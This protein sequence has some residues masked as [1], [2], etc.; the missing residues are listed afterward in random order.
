MRQIAPGTYV[1]CDANTC[2]VL[3]ARGFPTYQE[4][5]LGPSSQSLSNASMVVVTPELRTYFTVVNTSLC[6]DITPVILASFG[7]VSIQV[8]DTAG[9][10]AYKAALAQDVQGRI[11]LGQQLL[12]SGRVSASPAAESELAGG[13]VD[14]R[15]LLA[16]E[17]VASHQPIAVLAFSDSGPGAS[18]G[19][20]LRLVDLATTD[21]ASGMT[22]SAYVQSL[23]Q[24]LNAHSS[25]PAYTRA[26]P[27]RLSDGQ[28]AVQIEY[29]APSPLGLLTP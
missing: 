27:V 12:N 2:P 19:I 25:F 14:S 21:P 16:L 11:K 4:V 23:G 20:P 9:A 13:Q 26:R 8:I 29:A 24:L 22:A 5:Q 7:Q 28:T 17:A 18:Q 3:T 1:A 6:A 10:V 15:L